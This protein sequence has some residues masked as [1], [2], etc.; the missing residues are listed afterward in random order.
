MTSNSITQQSTEI[1][2]HAH[3][4]TDNPAQASAT[5]AVSRRSFIGKAGL[6]TAAGVLAP[7]LPG[8][9]LAGKD[10][11]GD[12][13]G[14]ASAGHDLAEKYRNDTH[15]TLHT[16]ELRKKSFKARIK[17]AQEE[18]GFEIPPQPNNG[19]EA[20]YPNGISVGTKGLKH[21]AEG[22]VDPASYASLL[23]ALKS[24]KHEDFEN[25]VL[26]GTAKLADPEGPL[27][28]ALE[29]ISNA[30]L[31][32]PLAA[33]LDSAELAA[34]HIEVYWQALL[35]DVPFSEYRNDTSNPLVLAAVDELNKL[36][37][38]NGPR[39]GG[40]VTPETLFRSTAAYVDYAA[41]ASG[42][43]GKYV[44]PP[45]T[46]EGPYISQ[47]LLRPVP[48]WGTSPAQPQTRPIQK[49]GETFGT[50]F[51]EWLKLRNGI[52]TGKT[53][54]TESGRRHIINGRDLAWLARNSGP[55]YLHVLQILLTAPVAGNPLAGG[56]GAPLNPAN[57]YVKSK[58]L[59]AGS[60]FSGSFIQALVA[61]AGPLAIKTSY[62]QNWYVNRRLRPEDYG[63]LV[64]KI[65]AKGAHYPI[66]EDILGSDALARTFA[67]FGSY[68]L[69]LANNSG[70]PTHP[71]YPSGATISAAT[72][73]TLLKAYFDENHVIPNPVQVDPIDPT[74]LIPYVG[75]PLTVGGELN[76]LVNNIGYGRNF[77]GFHIRSDISASHTL[78]EALA[79]SILR[80]QRFT[81]NET[82]AGYT[83]TKFDGS[84][85][86]V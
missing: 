26:G 31:A 44:V 66:H 86:S 13:H 69:P 68:L 72:P 54:T 16:R 64:H 21:D 45:G 42:K 1:D 59:N 2:A 77:N 61:L 65:L 82:F 25:I 5:G 28:T 15:G 55:T 83:F 52:S 80:D 46:L 14:K 38:F 58:T 36:P 57:P 56:V 20:R 81:Y 49:A 18:Y 19:D 75:A 78:G 76:K 41:D 60:S 71:G 17:A 9:A 39:S 30:Q 34:D 73:V 12:D 3:G 4:D 85:I 74:K 24:G 6:L 29:G 22:H 23:K 35:R 8:T 67:A 33:R 48:A 43:T 53:I 79:I 10:E 63:G 51:D 50:D 40:Q 7:A 47:F 70:A 32:I 37:A 11:G 27:T 84:Q 62:Y